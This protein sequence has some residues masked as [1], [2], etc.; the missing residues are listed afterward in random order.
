MLTVVIFFV[1]GLFNSYTATITHDKREFGM[2]MCYLFPVRFVYLLFVL[3]FKQAMNDMMK[4]M[5]DLSTSKN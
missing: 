3:G 1:F 4:K 2:R 5:D